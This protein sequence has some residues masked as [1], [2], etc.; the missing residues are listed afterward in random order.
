MLEADELQGGSIKG[1][2]APADTGGRPEGITEDL[3]RRPM[4]IP[5]R[6]KVLSLVAA[7]L[8]P[9]AASAQPAADPPSRT[10]ASCPVPAS[11]SGALAAEAKRL[12]AEGPR[13]IGE[14]Y[15]P[16]NARGYNYAADARGVETQALEFEARGQTGEKP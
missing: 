1:R 5:T 16:L 6:R 3:V 15:R 12:E 10:A 11:Q 9:I 14:G 13:A 2:F 7:S 4:P 8:L